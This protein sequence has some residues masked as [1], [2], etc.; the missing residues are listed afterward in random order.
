VADDD[1]VDIVVWKLRGSRGSA[2]GRSGRVIG[3]CYFLIKK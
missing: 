2:V 1:D 3:I